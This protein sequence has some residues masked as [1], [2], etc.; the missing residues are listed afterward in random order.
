LIQEESVLKEL[1]EGIK[2]VK[3]VTLDEKCII[4]KGSRFL[5]GKTRCPI[6]LR[7]YAQ[8]KIKPMVESLTLHGSSPP[9]I[10][11]GR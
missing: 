2:E 4:C 6:L 1:D 10:F 11:V 9:D 3:T 8:L 5:C 7:L